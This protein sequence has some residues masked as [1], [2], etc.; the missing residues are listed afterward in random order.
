MRAILLF[1]QLKSLEPHCPRCPC[2]CEVSQSGVGW[3]PGGGKG[4]VCIPG[5]SPGSAQCRVGMGHTFIQRQ[6]A[7][8]QRC[9][10]HASSQFVSRNSR[11]FLWGL[12]LRGWGE[13]VAEGGAGRALL[14]VSGRKHLAGICEETICRDATEFREL[15][16]M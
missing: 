3:A 8:N 6:M 12:R 14:R 7:V 11:S 10:V 16:G 4:E 2:T 13:L 5:P 1:P 9:S 15:R